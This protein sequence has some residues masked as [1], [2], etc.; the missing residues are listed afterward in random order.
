MAAAHKPHLISPKKNLGIWSLGDYESPSLINETRWHYSMHPCSE[1][2]TLPR[3]RRFSI[4]LLLSTLTCTSAG[5]AL[6][7]GRKEGRKDILGCDILYFCCDIFSSKCCS[8]CPA[9]LEEVFHLQ[10]SAAQGQ[11]QKPCTTTTLKNK[12]KT[13]THKPNQPHTQF[14][15]PRDFHF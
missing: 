14:H 5:P 6:Y 7:K 2:E 10:L 13:Q 15:K 1:A 3:T 4:H 8:L 12:T 9:L 11:F